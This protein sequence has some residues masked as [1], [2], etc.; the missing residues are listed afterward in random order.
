MLR[1]ELF[2][3]IKEVFSA[4]SSANFK[5]LAQSEETLFEKRICL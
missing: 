4:L 5:G 2:F 1:Y 3:I